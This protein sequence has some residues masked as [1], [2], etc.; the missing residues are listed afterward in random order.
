MFCCILLCMRN[1]LF[2]KYLLLILHFTP[3]LSRSKC[4]D[5]LIQA[6]VYLLM[7]DNQKWV[8]NVYS[9]IKVAAGLGFSPWSCLIH[10]LLQYLNYCVPF[11]FCQTR[12][13]RELEKKFSG[14]HVVIVAQVCDFLHS[15]YFLVW[16]FFFFTDSVWLLSLCILVLS[17][18]GVF[19][20][21]ILPIAFGTVWV[22]QKKIF[23]LANESTFYTYIAKTLV[24]YFLE[25]LMLE[26]VKNNAHIDVRCT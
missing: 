3:C 2:S 5:I 21:K 13:V 14:K 17:L 7:K 8:F 20:M 11:C 6:A 19:Y 12:L 24:I 25:T 4:D 22:G 23:F 10:K 16:L 26:Q 9:P 15:C 18:S 1:L